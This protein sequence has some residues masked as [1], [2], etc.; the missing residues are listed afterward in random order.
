MSGKK[1]RANGIGAVEGA[2]V[3]EAAF[4]CAEL[5]EADEDKTPELD[6]VGCII[7]PRLPP[8]EDISLSK[9]I[10]ISPRGTG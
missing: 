3:N 8:F 6:T 7:A 2:L 5:T 10:D 9:Y 1:S 4:D